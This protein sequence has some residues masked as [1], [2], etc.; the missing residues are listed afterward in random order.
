M[1][2]LSEPTMTVATRAQLERVRMAGS[3]RLTD[4]LFKQELVVNLRKGNGN[5]AA[6]EPLIRSAGTIEHDAFLPVFVSVRRPKCNVETFGVSIHVSDRI[7]SSFACSSSK[8]YAAN[9]SSNAFASFRSRVSNPSVNQPYT[10]ASSS[11][12]CRTLPWSRQRR[13]RLMAARSSQDFACC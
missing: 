9:S 1:A 4:S 8:G 2:W 6:S 5:K 10:G 3:H 13:A 7:G 12:A 11:R